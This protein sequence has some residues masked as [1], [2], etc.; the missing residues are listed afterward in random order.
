MATLQ[1]QDRISLNY[2]GATFRPSLVYLLIALALLFTFQV[3]H[4]PRQ[5]PPP[6]A[7]EEPELIKLILGF[8]IVLVLLLG[9]ADGFFVLGQR[10]FM[11]KVS[12]DELHLYVNKGGSQLTIPL[13][14]V[15]AVSATTAT[16][17]TPTR[18]RVT[19]YIVFYTSEG[20]VEKLN[21]MVYPKTRDSFELFIQRIKRV[22]PGLVVREA[23]SPVDRIF[24]RK[25]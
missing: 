1:D 19:N 13:S 11:K 5:L 16:M 9:L 6:G 10:F 21:L 24:T 17:R 2:E 8:A 22:N 3:I 18:G 23:A 15:E 14:T 25:G 7:A 20:R 4:F 12:F